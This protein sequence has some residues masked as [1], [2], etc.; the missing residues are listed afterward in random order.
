MSHNAINTSKK[1]FKLSNQGDLTA[2]KSMIHPNAT[3]SSINTGMYFGVDDIMAMMKNFFAQYSVLQW[4]IDDIKANSTHIVEVTFTC[5][6]TDRQ[7]SHTVL[8]GTEMLVVD[9]DLIRHI[10]VR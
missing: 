2:I 4:Q 8:T 5:H 10:E 1:Y 3:Y 7:G 9:N 6:L